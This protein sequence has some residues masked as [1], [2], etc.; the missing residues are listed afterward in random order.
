MRC[1]VR[2]PRHPAYAWS[3]GMMCFRLS[4]DLAAAYAAI[5]R[6]V[7]ALVTELEHEDA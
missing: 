5:R 4:Q 3:S 2:G 6:R 1:D 7:E